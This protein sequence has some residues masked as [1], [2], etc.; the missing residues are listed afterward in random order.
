MQDIPTSGPVT[1]RTTYDGRGGARWAV[2]V[3]YLE[4]DG[5]FRACG[6]RLRSF[7][8]EDLGDALV[9]RS[10]NG[11]WEAV[12][13][14]AVKLI[15]V[16]TLITEARRS[17]TAADLEDHEELWDAP[18]LYWDGRPADR[19]RARTR[20][21]RQRQMIRRTEGRAA[22]NDE[23]WQAVAR[24]YSEAWAADVPPTA[25]VAEHFNIARNTAGQW[26]YKARRRG[27]LPAT[28][29]RRPR[30]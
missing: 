30:A 20:L 29:E 14:A 12:T 9:A 13:T 25:A 17:I 3:E 5:Q 6:L 8:V 11:S 24:V 28:D 27:L 23:H 10:L 26:V 4:V 22:Y 2:E 1:G 18:G 16:A 19:A 21:D 7:D 15:P